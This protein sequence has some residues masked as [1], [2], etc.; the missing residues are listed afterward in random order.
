[1]SDSSNLA[2]K[3]RERLGEETED[4]LGKALSDALEGA[5]SGQ[6]Q[7]LNARALEVELAPPPGLGPG[8]GLGLGFGH[9]PALGPAERAQRER[10]HALGRVAQEVVVDAR[11][12]AAGVE[13]VADG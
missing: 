13:R 11:A 2:K 7:A 6:G 5:G 1:M 3:V 9:A 10:P 4:R 8:P 12:R